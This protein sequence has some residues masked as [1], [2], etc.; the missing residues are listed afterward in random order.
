MPTQKL[1][2]QTASTQRQRA[3]KPAKQ[4]SQPAGAQADAARNP[5]AASPDAILALQGQI[6]NR[7]VQRMLA[8]KNVQTKLSVGP[9][10]DTYEQEA[11]RV[12]DSV[13]RTLNPQ[14]NHSTSP[15]PSRS[16]PGPSPIQQ[17]SAQPEQA[18]AESAAGFDAGAQWEG[19]LNAS[20]AAGAPLP[21][22][23]RASM[24][25]SFGA[26]FNKVRVHT[27]PQAA[28]L[29]RSIQAD[30][31]T[32]GSDIFFDQGKYNPASKTGQRL[33]AHELT[34]VVQQNS[35]GAVKRK[36]G[37]G[38]VEVKGH[39]APNRISTKKK[40]MHLDFVRMKRKKA[41][42]GKKIAEMMGG[43]KAHD[44]Y[45]HWWTEI[46][47]LDATDAWTPNES[48][49]WWPSIKVN[50]E[51]T[52]KGVPGQLNKGQPTDPHHG[53]NADE[54]FHPVMSVDDQ[55]DYD[56]VKQD[57]SGKIRSFATAFKGTW[58]WR[59][60]WGKNC[61]TFQQRLKKKVHLHNQKSNRWLRD[62]QVVAAKQQLQADE[63]RRQQAEADR[64]KALKPQPTHLETTPYMM[65]FYT[66]DDAG[67]VKKVGMLRN[68]SEIGIT[69]LIKN[70]FVQFT[71]G[72]GSNMQWCWARTDEYA[73]ALGKPYPGTEQATADPEASVDAGGNPVN[74]VV[75]E[76]S[77]G[78]G[79]DEMSGD[80]IDITNGLPEVEDEQPKPDAPGQDLPGQDTPGEDAPGF[81]PPAPRSVV[82]VKRPMNM[83]YVST[84]TQMRKDVIAPAG[85]HLM[86]LGIPADGKLEVESDKLGHGFVN[87][88]D[89]QQAL[90]D[91]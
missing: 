61:H 83:Q 76:D 69:G 40:K 21:I 88:A 82:T 45:G 81:T 14:S 2:P 13:M 19:K 56:T 89:L 5:K 26:D 74:D 55:A 12:A 52:L 49:G 86:I 41:H 27:G 1:P 17:R 43:A 44:P 48:Y 34:H 10:A 67:A 78:G 35:A 90:E 7:G 22:G 51:Q 33:L 57:V 66:M 4:A 3:P 68:G 50:V 85:S 37:T 77:G 47:D 23:T 75:G 79:A 11:D 28:Q 29:N 39:L 58:N 8:S 62:P 25:N 72:T 53:H 16:E 60:G 9:A 6:G 24:E 30:A 73:Q 15:Q 80:E 64:L 46:G 84:M 71:T 65:D 20:G 59:F 42:V 70:G 18:P 87:L 63:D 32:H 54:T 38:N 36:M 31:F 91:A